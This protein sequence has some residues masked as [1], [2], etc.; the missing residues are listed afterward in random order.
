MKVRVGARVL[1]PMHAILTW[2][3]TQRLALAGFHWL[4]HVKQLG[5]AAAYDDA[6]AFLR[7]APEGVIDQG[8]ADDHHPE[9]R[10]A[11]GPWGGGHRRRPGR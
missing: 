1:N 9:G 6:A 3:E 8:V 2:E 5:G 4:R 7:D 10:P 11:G